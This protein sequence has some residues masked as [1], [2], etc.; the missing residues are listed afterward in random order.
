MK[1]PVR[2][3]S[4]GLTVADF[5]KILQNRKAL[6]FLVFFLVV[7]TTAG[8]TA[9]MPKWYV[10]TAG[11][12]V[13]KPE[14][15]VTLFQTQ[16]LGSF[17]PYYIKE[18]FEIIQSKKILEPVIGKLDLARLLG[19]R[20]G[21]NLTAET[22]FTYLSKKMLR[23]QSR[24]GTSLI[25]VGVMVREDPELAAKIAN[26]I[27]RAYADDR[28][29]FAVSGQTEGI[30]KLKEELQ[31]QESE[32]SA[33]RDRVEKLRE[34]LGISGIDINNRAMQLEIENLR[35]I[36]RTLIHLKVDS[37]ARKTR[38]ERFKAVAL[39]ERFKLV[40]SELIPDT[41]I[42]NLMQAYL[43][44]EQNHVRLKGRLGEAHPELVASSE[45]IKMIHSQL[46]DLL[47]GYEQ[48][49]E[50]SYIEAQSR[51]EALEKELD[52]ARL[53]QIVTAQSRLRPFEEA[54]E[55]LHDEKNLYKTIKLTLRQREI[56]FQVPKRTIEILNAA[57][58]PSRAF[59]PNWFIN[60]G[61][62]LVVGSL[63]G[64]GVAFL[65][66]FLDTSF[67]SV[68]DMERKLQL[69]ILGVVTRKQVMVSEDNYNSSDAEPFRV[70]ET[71]LEL[72]SGEESGTI[73]VVQS[74][75]PGEG[76]STTLYNLASV[77][78]L[79]GQR[80]LVLDTDL[81]RPTQ[82]RLFAIERHPGLIDYLKGARGTKEIIRTTSVPNLE[83]IACGE[84]T[85]FSL[86]I[87][88]GRKV[89]DLLTQLRG[90]YDKILLDSPP[91]IG[92][93]DSAILASMADG[94][95]FIVQ[96]R[97][98]PQSMTM[99]ARQILENVEG[100]IVGVVLNQVPQSGSE[101]YNYYT[102]NYYY[103]SHKKERIADLPE[104]QRTDD[105]EELVLEEADVD[106]RTRV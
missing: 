70:I 14:G 90:S 38:W 2:T 69:P 17:D 23:M 29:A 62:A 6:I 81:R 60:I 82:H 44:A 50:I 41:N 39:Q 3:T 27:A 103:Y 36:E 11:I 46:E 85:H 40:N 102:S 32:V 92:I 75:G 8:V 4:E 77:M 20:M 59:R 63:L 16:V 61:L 84:G 26:D 79:S 101:D 96:H 86:T 87:L 25:D 88:H 99:R 74:A 33:Q 21:S 94:V 58:P 68:E 9:I 51:V 67:R 64:I 106:R 31:K 48:S 53:D 78:A 24:P 28:I 30:A 98:N 35:Q 97:R 89:V 66:E 71:N 7:I 43:V 5:L 18:Q 22:T 42:Q 54:V 37:I 13:E 57:I 83:V 56:D 105:I 1:E 100:R 47:E 65:V 73:F 104:K 34:E 76:K 49:L 52:R 80:V 12:R 15:E 55:R 45:G 72:A 19:E 91:V 95:I 10:A 93:S